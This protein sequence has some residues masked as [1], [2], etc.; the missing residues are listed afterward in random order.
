MQHRANSGFTKFVNRCLYSNCR[1]TNGREKNRMYEIQCTRTT[2][3]YSIVSHSLSS[4][5]EDNRTTKQQGYTY[6]KKCPRKFINKK[7]Y[8]CNS[9]CNG[10]CE[11]E[12]R[13]SEQS[14]T[15]YMDARTENMKRL[16]LQLQRQNQKNLLHRKTI[17]PFKA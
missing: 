9:E 12:V 13:L 11:R 7:Q 17:F 6:M 2:G 5:S 10:V 3:K 14:V 4:A 8:Y 1:K 16:T 15:E